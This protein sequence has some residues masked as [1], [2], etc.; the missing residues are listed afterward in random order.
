MDVSIHVIDG[1]PPQRRL[2]LTSPHSTKPTCP[3]SVFQTCQAQWGRRVRLESAVAVD[4]ASEAQ[5][6]G[7]LAVAGLHSPTSNLG[8]TALC[9]AAACWVPEVPSPRNAADVGG[10][11]HWGC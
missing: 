1:T 10:R 7:A 5:P 3:V 6:G 11:R 2:Q 9:D 4:G 8:E